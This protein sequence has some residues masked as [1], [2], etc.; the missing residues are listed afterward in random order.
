MIRKL[1][2]HSNLHSRG[3]YLNMHK[4][5]MSR[6]Q[7]AIILMAMAAVVLSFTIIRAAITDIT[8]DEA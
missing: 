2:Y 1:Y 6:N 7:K 3:E 5:E 4:L 8:Y